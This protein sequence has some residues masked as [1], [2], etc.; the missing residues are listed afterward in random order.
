MR[1]FRNLEIEFSGSS[2]QV[3][4]VVLARRTEKIYT[5]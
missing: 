1:N 5:K 4:E 2:L 3:L